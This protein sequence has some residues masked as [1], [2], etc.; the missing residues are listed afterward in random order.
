M[1]F[2][3][4]RTVYEHSIRA[5]L[6]WETL[7]SSDARIEEKFLTSPQELGDIFTVWFTDPLGKHGDWRNPHHKPMTVKE[8]AHAPESWT[9]DK[10]RRIGEFFL[11]YTQFSEPLIM[12]LPTYRVDEKHILL[13]A[14][15]RTVAAYL[16]QA[17]VR[18]IVHSI[19]GPANPR[20]LPDLHWFTKGHV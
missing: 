9:T 1:D 13:D 7:A 8:A 6:D 10:K 5:W 12:T 20:I 11:E 18:V 19:L 17:E 4:F 15:H 16:A 2:S 3:D 14:S